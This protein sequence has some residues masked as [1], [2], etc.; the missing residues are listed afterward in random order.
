MG[1]ALSPKASEPYP[2]QSPRLFLTGLDEANIRT[3]YR[4]N[5]DAELH[6]LQCDGP[7]ARESYGAFARR[8]QQLQHNSIERDFDF[9]SHRRGDTDS[10][11]GIASIYDIDP[12]SRHARFS[13]TIGR[14]E[15]WNQGYGRQ[16]LAMLL[17]FGFDTLGLHRLMTTALTF[18]TAWRHLLATSGFHREGCLREH[19][20]R[21]NRYWDKETYA[22]LSR[23]YAASHALAA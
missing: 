5:N 19:I 11:I 3:H 17:R 16:T 12:A 23:E 9:E 6:A 20:Y 4:W 18:N 21:H 1:N 2:L 14:R 15:A 22:L 7:F 10:L 13:L 8:F